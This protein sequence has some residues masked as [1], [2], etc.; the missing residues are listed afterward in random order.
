M[1]PRDFADELLGENEEF[2][3]ETP[4]PAKE[5]IP[6]GMVRRMIDV[7]GMGM[8]RR[9]SHVIRDVALAAAER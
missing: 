8:L 9:N 2:R 3:Q 7:E 1:G 6:G 4:S 5:A